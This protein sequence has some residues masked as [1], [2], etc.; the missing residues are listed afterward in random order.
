MGALALTIV[1]C[2]LPDRGSLHAIRRALMPFGN[3]ES[4]PTSSVLMAKTIPVLR[5]SSLLRQ[6]QKKVYPA[7]ISLISHSASRV[8]LS[9]AICIPYHP[10]SLPTMAVLRSICSSTDNQ[11]SHIFYMPLIKG[12]PF[13]FFFLFQPLKRIPDDHG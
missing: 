7:P 10:S 11:C 1:A 8:S 2:L 3:H 9:A 12:I 5:F 13:V 4:L 6:V